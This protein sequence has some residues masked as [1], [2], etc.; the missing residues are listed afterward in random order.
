MSKHFFMQYY[1]GEWLSD[2]KVSQCRPATRGI[3][4]GGM[5]YLPCTESIAAGNWAVLSRLGSAVA[6]SMRCVQQLMIFTRPVRPM[7]RSVTAW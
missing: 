6:E 7:S 3:L 2:A 1:P 5:P 4:S